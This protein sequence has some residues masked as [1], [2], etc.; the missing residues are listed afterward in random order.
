MRIIFR[1]KIIPA[2][3]CLLLTGLLFSGCSN[4]MSPVDPQGTTPP[5]PPKQTTGTQEHKVTYNY[6]DTGPIQLSANN[7]VLSVG[8]KLILAPAPGLT[9][10]TRFTSSGENFFGDIMQQEG[11][12]GTGQVVFVAK[13]AGKG[14]L[15]IIPNTNE[16]SRATELWVTVQ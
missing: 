5:S 6:G 3:I 12:T 9:K 16:T 4:N 1:T 2:V 11:D 10:N 7:L 15:Q 13:K 14:K 8:Q